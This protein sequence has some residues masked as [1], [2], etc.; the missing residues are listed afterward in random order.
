MENEVLDRIKKFAIQEL[1]REYGFCA[2]ADGDQDVMLDAT[3][4]EGNDIKIKI[5][6][7]VQ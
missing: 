3:D 4:R 7:R 6:A 5:S 2:C 1:Q